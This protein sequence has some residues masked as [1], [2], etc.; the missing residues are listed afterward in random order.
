[1]AVDGTSNLCVHGGGVGLEGDAECL[2]QVVCW[3]ANNLGRNFM[4]GLNDLGWSGERGGHCGGVRHGGGQA[5][6]APKNLVCSTD[7]RKR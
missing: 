6:S 3:N 2:E 5:C 4:E 1:M 7:E